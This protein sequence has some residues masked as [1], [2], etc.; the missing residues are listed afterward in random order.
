MSYHLTL[1]N[2]SCERDERLLFQHINQ[3]F[4]SGDIYQIAGPNGAGKTTLMKIIV[5]LVAADEGTVEWQGNQSQGNEPP[6]ERTGLRDSLLYFGHQ[7]AVNVSLSALENIEW[8]FGLNGQ[9][10]AGSAEVPGRRACIKALEKVGLA[11]YEHVHCFQMSAGQQRR[12]ALARLYLSEAPLWILD[13]PFTAIDKRGVAEL[14]QNIALHAE[15]GGIILLT[16]HQA[17]HLPAV[18]LL[19][20]ADYAPG[21]A[22]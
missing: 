14:E 21:E 8:Y 7:A 10:S 15:R 17:M 20:L 19:D 13:E 6:Q 18:K 12:V 4:D 16:S 9:K 22:L 11:G 1:N 3:Q 5:G 2:I